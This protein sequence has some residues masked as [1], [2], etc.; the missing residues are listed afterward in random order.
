MTTLINC[1]SV[2]NKQFPKSTLMNFNERFNGFKW[3]ILR[4]TTKITATG[5]NYC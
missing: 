2:F 3:N 1:E 4:F 5:E